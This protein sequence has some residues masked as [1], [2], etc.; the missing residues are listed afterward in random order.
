MVDQTVAPLVSALEQLV[1]P[2]TDQLR[3][4]D[5]ALEPLAEQ[6]AHH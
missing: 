6:L 4:E 1:S 5:R 2:F 3:E